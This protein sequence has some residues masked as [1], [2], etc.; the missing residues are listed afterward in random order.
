MKKIVAVLMLLVLTVGMMALPVSAATPKEQLIACT[1]ENMPEQLVTKYLPA[2]E[3]TLRYI[4]VSQEQ[5]DQ[6]CAIIVETREYFETTGGFKGVTLHY[7]SREQQMYAVDVVAEICEILGLT[8]RY[9]FS[10]D[11]DHDFDVVITIYDAAGRRL[12]IMDGDAI[13][14]TNV[15]YAVNYTYVAGAVALLLAAVAAAIVGKKLA[16]R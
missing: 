11:A 6:I 15:P 14:Q 10:T 9:T 4:T 7:Y 1:R 3:N 16:A 8:S 5:A 13:K 12:A 2:I